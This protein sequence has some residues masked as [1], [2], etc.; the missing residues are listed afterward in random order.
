MQQ[1]LERSLFDVDL[2]DMTVEENIHSVTVAVHTTYQL[3]RRTT[4]VMV[5]VCMFG[6]HF[7]VD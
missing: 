1:T 4:C 5:Y 3:S 6:K 2:V 7:L